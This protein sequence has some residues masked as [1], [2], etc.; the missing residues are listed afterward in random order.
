[1]ECRH[2]GG[3]CYDGTID[4]LTIWNKKLSEEEVRLERHLIKSN[5]VI[6]DIIAYY[7]MNEYRGEELRIQD[8]TGNYNLNN[9]DSDLTTSDVPIGGGVSEKQTINALEPI[10][11]LTLN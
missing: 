1:M 2:N 7:Q 4:E 11:F 3:D 9:N 5:L 8:F 6:T 10:I